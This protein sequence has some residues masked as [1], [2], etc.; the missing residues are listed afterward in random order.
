MSKSCLMAAGLLA[1]CASATAY[2]ADRFI[3]P[4]ASSALEAP[5]PADSAFNALAVAGR[6][7]IAVGR[8]GLIALSDDQGT[9]WRQAQVPVQSDL[10]AVSFPTPTEGWAV[11]H[12]GVILHTTDA[13]VNWV[14]QLD[15]NEAARL[16]QAQL[17]AK[18][19]AHQPDTQVLLQVGDQFAA[20]GADKPF[21][22]VWFADAHHGYVVGAFGMIFETRDAGQHWQTLVD[23]VDNPDG[24]HLYAIRGYSAG[25]ILA[26]ERG[27][28]E[29]WDTASERFI[30]GDADIQSSLFGLQRANHGMY[31][32]GMQGK[33]LFSIDGTRWAA[34]PSAEPGSLLAA[35]VTT[36][37]RPVLLSQTGNLLTLAPD[38]GLTRYPSR[39]GLPMNA[40]AFDNNRVLLAGERG[41]RRVALP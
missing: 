19:S 4:L 31:A 1:L 28:L 30:R 26:G 17:Q 5:H 23:K 25:L 2:A 13:G 24:L 14:L 29:K 34:V 37:D 35:T 6:R 11:G 32:F 12:D 38:G 16:M 7:S 40:I 3:D 20:D 36:D 9:H 21:L 18:A 33:V 27:L 15:G 39:A 8:H 22:D 41:I 10:T